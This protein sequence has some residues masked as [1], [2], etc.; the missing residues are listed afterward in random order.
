MQL[1]KNIVVCAMTAGFLGLPT[2][3]GV[4]GGAEKS[5]KPTK[6]CVQQSKKGNVELC[7][8]QKVH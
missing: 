1:A 3:F 7:T 8:T 2:Q 4:W 6:C 5:F